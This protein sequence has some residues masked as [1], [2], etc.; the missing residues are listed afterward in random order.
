[1]LQSII[2]EQCYEHFISLHVSMTV[3]LS[4]THERLLNFIEKLLNYYV[5]KFGE[6]CGKEFMSHNIHALLHLI[7]D[8]KQFG[9]LDNCSCFP[10]ENFM[11]LLKK[12]VRSLCSKLLNG[13]KN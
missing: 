8:Y 9:P 13:M 7:D 12:M 10:Y 2:D 5:I 6:M 11:Q 3:L 1:V 4:R